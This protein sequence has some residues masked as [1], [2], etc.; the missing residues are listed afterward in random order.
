[1]PDIDATTRNIRFAVISLAM[2]GVLSIPTYFIKKLGGERTLISEMFNILWLPGGLIA[3][4]IFHGQTFDE[5]DVF[6]FYL[7]G[8]VL[9]FVF[10][11]ILMF[12]LIHFTR[13]FTMPHKS[14]MD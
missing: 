1:M 11:T 7:T 3:R 10:Y 6:R 14:T 4:L 12:L 5:S 8:A 2:S 13:A 9:N